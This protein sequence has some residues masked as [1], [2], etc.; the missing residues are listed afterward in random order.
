MTQILIN[1]DFQLTK[2]SFETKEELLQELM[3]AS[4]DIILQEVSEDEL[5][6]EV[7][8]DY[9]AHLR[10]SSDTLVNI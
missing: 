6:L 10:S 7:K 9:D 1:E 2:N 3:E 8:R 5:P 4:G